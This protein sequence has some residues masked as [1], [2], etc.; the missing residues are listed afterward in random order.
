MFNPSFPVFPTNLSGF[1]VSRP[2]RR[3]GASKPGAAI[4]EAR[5]GEGP[6]SWVVSRWWSLGRGKH[7]TGAPGRWFSWKS[8][9]TLCFT[10]VFG[11]NIAKNLG[12][13][14][15]CCF[16]VL[17][18]WQHMNKNTLLYSGLWL[19]PHNNLSFELLFCLNCSDQADKGLDRFFPV[20]PSLKRLFNCFNRDMYV[21]L[22]FFLYS[23]LYWIEHQ[24]DAA[25]TFARIMLLFDIAFLR[26]STFKQRNSW[27]RPSCNNIY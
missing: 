8:T 22:N 3:E 11:W 14:T 7:R 1:S 24:K 27:T 15:I 17:L 20:K 26:A 21:L 18:L 9:K 4:A 16:N 25:S 6:K 5:T 2:G 19:T 23:Q 10:M 13:G 12:F